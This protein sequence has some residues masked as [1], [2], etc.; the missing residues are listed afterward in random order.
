TFDD[1]NV[2]PKLE[3]KIE[4]ASNVPSKIFKPYPISDSGRKILSKFLSEEIKLGHIKPIAD[5]I[6]ALPITIEPLKNRVC[7]D[8]RW[9]NR[10]IHGCDLSVPS[11]EELLIKISQSEYFS[12]FDFRRAFKLM[13]INKEFEKFN[14]ISTCYGYYSSDRL[15]FG[16]KSASGLFHLMISDLLR[17]LSKNALWYVDDVLFFGDLDS[18]RSAIIEFVKICSINGLKFNIHKMQLFKK[19]VTFL[20]SLISSDGISVHPSRIAELKILEKPKSVNVMQRFLGKYVFISKNIENYCE[21]VNPLYP[22]KDD[23]NDG[24]VW[25]SA[26]EKAFLRLKDATQNY[27]TLTPPLP[28][29]DLFL[30]H[31]PTPESL[32]VEL[33]NAKDDII[34]IYMRT[35]TSA[36]NNYSDLEKELLLISSYINLSLPFI[37]E[38]NIIWLTTS[39]MI[40]KMLQ[41]P[42]DLSSNASS[43]IQSLLAPL[44]ER[45]NVEVKIFAA[46]IDI[47][48]F[49]DISLTKYLTNGEIRADQSSSV[50]CLNLFKYFDSLD[51]KGEYLLSIPK[52]L[53]EEIEL[54]NV[55]E[56]II[57]I[58]GKPIISSNLALIVI[59]EIHRQSHSGTVIMVNEASLWYFFKGWSSICA[60]V[61]DECSLCL[62]MKAPTHKKTTCWSPALFPRERGHYDICYIDNNPIIMLCDSFSN[63]VMVKMLKSKSQEN[64][65]SFFRPLLEQFPWSILISDNEP[66]LCGPDLAMLFQEFHVHHVTSIPYFPASNGLV[67]KYIHIFKTKVKKFMLSSMSLSSSISAAV[68]AI[69][70]F[71]NT[72]RKISAAQLFYTSYDKKI[73]YLPPKEVV[74]PNKMIYFLPKGKLSS[75]YLAGTLVATLGSRINVVL[76]EDMKY[77]VSVDHCHYG[78][79]KYNLDEVLKD[80]PNLFT[81]P[82]E[83]DDKTLKLLDHDHVDDDAFLYNQRELFNKECLENSIKSMKELL[84][85][86]RKS[87]HKNFLFIDGSIKN[88]H[89]VGIYGLLHGIPVFISKR[90]YLRGR[91]TS[92]RMEVE[93]LMECMKL[94]QSKGV[95]EA[96]I[97]SDNSYVVNSVN[98]GW[99]KLW[100]SEEGKRNSRNKVPAHI[101][102]WKSI[103]EIHHP[104]YK[105]YHVQGH[106]LEPHNVADLLAKGE[107]INELLESIKK[108]NDPDELF[109]TSEKV[110]PLQLN[111]PAPE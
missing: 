61:L 12:T 84:E 13:R 69:N 3:V 44:S 74:V 96:D 63:Y 26:R 34:D 21:I 62:R 60:R 109:P 50:V 23:E 25:S 18:Q 89:G 31:V 75:T 4:L 28:G 45:N 49:S 57:C 6:V 93:A 68:H 94:L 24:Y 103:M 99:A 43:R 58:D 79:H 29:E 5:P 88:G 52:Y 67:E 80:V 53:R 17:S 91:V 65:V 10:F 41:T 70:H 27:L 102:Q 47:S 16:I 33:R 101:N 8:S 85:L 76:H 104:N 22:R 110:P 83:H 90:G 56:G 37:F 32:H 54:L 95:G 14:V 20:G 40:S 59:R 81:T 108:Y 111:L 2:E 100:L 73:D 38:R 77:Y 46:K 82:L 66:S 48:S 97:F 64:L 107:S 55:I 39:K 87:K 78:Y 19:S 11:K 86:I 7:T 15:Q 36:E 35:Y 72:K 71:A 9:I 106:Q 42:L 105:I 92:P 98:Q 1:S 30:H 51:K